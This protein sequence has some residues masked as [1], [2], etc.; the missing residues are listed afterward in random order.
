MGAS[1]KVRVSAITA[2]EEFFIGRPVKKS[3]RVDGE[4]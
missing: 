1:M 3:M 4:V 2:A